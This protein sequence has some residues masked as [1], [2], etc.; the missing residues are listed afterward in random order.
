MN[1]L[2]LLG[3]EGVNSRLQ[4]LVMGAVVLVCVGLGARGLWA[5]AARVLAIL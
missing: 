3:D 1:D 5:A 2:D 4:N